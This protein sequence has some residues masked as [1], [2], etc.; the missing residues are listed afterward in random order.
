MNVGASSWSGEGAPTLS[1]GDIH[2]RGLSPSRQA[3]GMEHEARE[4]RLNR[5]LA[6]AGLDLGGG[7]VPLLSYSNDT[8]RIG[9]CVLRICWRGDVR[10][11]EREALLAA[12]LPSEVRYP[13][14]IGAGRTGELTWTVT[15]WIDG[16][17]LAEAW[18][19]LNRHERRSAVDQ[20]AQALAALH[21]WSPP[22]H[23]AG[24]LDAQQDVVDLSDSV[25]VVGATLN[26]LPLDRAFALADHARVLP[27]VSPQLIDAVLKRL[28]DL[29]VHDPYSDPAEHIVVHGD[30]HLSNVL[31]GG[32]A[33]VGL[34][35]LEWARLGPPDLELEPFLRGVDWSGREPESMPAAEMAVVLGWLA[36]SYPGLFASPNLIQRLSLYQLTSTLRDLFTWPAA[37]TP[38]DRLAP[39]HPLNLLPMFAKSSSHL[40]RLLAP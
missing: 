36:D 34:L 23:P 37:P 32:G 13:A 24:L 38:P 39:D 16:V 17:P 22:K 28:H 4:E 15:R 19:R 29:A 12:L 1:A 10:R 9:S 31:W 30:A 25:S 6:D 14:L 20:L 2:S 21:Q 35:D 8:W 18:P 5:V 27:F 11:L 3:G 26:P 40:E 7:A 33:M